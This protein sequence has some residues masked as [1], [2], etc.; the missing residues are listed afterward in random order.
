MV[1]LSKVSTIKMMFLKMSSDS[2][3]YYFNVSATYC[4]L[5]YL[6]CQCLKI[7]CFQKSRELVL[8]L[9]LEWGSGNCTMHEE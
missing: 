7:V 1:L 5:D 2:Q 8:F 9:T 4:V 6:C 3:Y